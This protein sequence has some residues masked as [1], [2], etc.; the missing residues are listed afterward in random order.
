MNEAW[1]QMLAD[2]KWEARNRRQSEG[3]RSQSTIWEVPPYGRQMLG[4]DRK[5]ER[6]RERETG[7]CNMTLKK[8]FH[9]FF[10]SSFLLGK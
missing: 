9:R 1:R 2:S 4:V 5:R 7:N 8:E 6:E 10:I 3:R